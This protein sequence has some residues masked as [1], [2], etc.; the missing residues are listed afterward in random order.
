MAVLSAFFSWASTTAWLKAIMAITIAHAPI[1]RA[2][3]YFS[4]MTVGKVEKRICPKVVDVMLSTAECIVQIVRRFLKYF[5][6]ENMR[7]MKNIGCLRPLG[8]FFRRFFL[9]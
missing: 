6:L 3:I 2:F 8:K 1:L 9:P 7:D 4:F 5:E